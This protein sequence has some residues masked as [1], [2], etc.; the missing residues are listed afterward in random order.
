M[1]LLWWP[2]GTERLRTHIIPW[3]VAASLLLL[4]W[5][6]PGRCRA[7]PPSSPD[8]CKPSCCEGSSPNRTPGRRGQAEPLSPG[9]LPRAVPVL[10]VPGPSAVQ[11]QQA[12]RPFQG[13]RGEE[14]RA[15]PVFGRV[16]SPAA[17]LIQAALQLRRRLDR[18]RSSAEGAH[19]CTQ[20]GAGC[21][22]E[23]GDRE[24]AAQRDLQWWMGA[25]SSHIPGGAPPQLPPPHTTV[26]GE[27][28]GVCWPLCT[29]MPTF[30]QGVRV[31]CRQGKRPRITKR[32]PSR[33]ARPH[34]SY[35]GPQ[36]SP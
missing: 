21:R 4:L 29:W 32:A 11:S 36:W 12:R 35:R 28:Q 17:G 14:G 7:R 3:G 20:S 27:K 10:G 24:G 15:R 1:C 19:V 25:Q 30:L 23:G 8:L 31:L 22:Q 26:P 16:P 5:R 33:T 13:A 6:L 34:L 18:P 9:G 2:P